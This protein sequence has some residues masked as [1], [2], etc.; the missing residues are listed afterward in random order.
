MQNADALKYFEEKNVKNN[1]LIL[2]SENKSAASGSFWL[3]KIWNP[4]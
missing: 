2:R 1:E 3:S 4:N